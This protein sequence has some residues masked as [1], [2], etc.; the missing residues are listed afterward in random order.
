MLVPRTLTIIA[1]VLF[2]TA[3]PALGTAQGIESAPTG[4]EDLAPDQEQKG[5]ETAANRPGWLGVML[6]ASDDAK[7]VEIVQV[8]RQSPAS[9][10]GLKVGDRIL[11][12]DGDAVASPAEVQKA[13]GRH[14]AG[15]KTKLE[16]ARGEKTTKMDIELGSAPAPQALLRRQFIGQR[17]PALRA[18]TVGDE[19][20]AV[21]L[22]K[23]RGKPVV[24]DFWATWCGPCRPM[25]EQLGKLSEKV[26]DGA[27][28]V[29]VTS[30]SRSAVQK[31]LKTHASKFPVATTDEKVMQ[32]YFIASYPTVFV[33]DEKGKVA[34]VF[35]GLGHMPQIRKLVEKLAAK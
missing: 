18:K 28:F 4:V 17:A 22:S 33:L 19:A 26:G 16:L 35:V 11:S 29:G 6:E 31:H 32:E 27:H 9:K 13:V 24:I 7:G 21:E 3:L 2:L 15:Q 30:E 34:G 5:A 23:L 1:A 25:S 8:L 12:V 14:R 10:G 20:R